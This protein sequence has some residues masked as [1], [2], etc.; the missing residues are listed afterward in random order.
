[1]LVDEVDGVA[2][3]LSWPVVVVAF[4]EH[5]PVSVAGNRIEEVV[6]VLGSKELVLVMLI[7]ST[8]VCVRFEAASSSVVRRVG[9]L[10][11]RPVGMPPTMN[12]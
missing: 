1:M 7:M 10:I 9:S 6:S 4:P 11:H 3:R 5:E 8:C 12:C 2:D